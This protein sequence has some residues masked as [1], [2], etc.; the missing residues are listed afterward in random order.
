MF[1]R[2]AHL[3]NLL[4]C[5]LLPPSGCRR[6]TSTAG[7]AAAAGRPGGTPVVRRPRGASV[8]MVRG[9]DTRLVRPYLDAYE[10]T[11]GLEAAA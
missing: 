2:I 11:H 6:A 8:R 9:E 1:P 5:L 3:L 10:R 4:M 7:A